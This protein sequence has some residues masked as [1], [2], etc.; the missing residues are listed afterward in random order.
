MVESL[1]AAPSGSALALEPSSG[2]AVASAIIGGLALVTTVVFGVL[3]HRRPKGTVGWS[4]RRAGKSRYIL[5]QT[6]TAAAYSVE[7][8]VT[9]GG[10]TA[11]E[12]AFAVFAAGQQ[13]PYL[14]TYGFGEPARVIVRWA[15]RAKG[16]RREVWSTG[17]PA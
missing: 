7:V 3:G 15:R 11:G 1:L 17:L 4:L 13:E 16:R 10:P 14:I 5:E 12:T 2:A 6:G 9:R 8:E